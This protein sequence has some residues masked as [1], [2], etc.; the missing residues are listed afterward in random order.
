[1]TLLFL[2]MAERAAVWAPLFAEAGETM[3]IGEEAVTDPAEITHILCWVPPVDIARYPNLKV[4]ISVGAGADQ[5][6]PLPPGVALSR[7]I[8]PGIDGMVRDWIVM[9]TLMLH[10]D[11]PVYIAQGHAAQWAPRRSLPANRT[12]VGIMGLGRIGRLAAETLHALGF[13]VTGWCRSGTPLP[14]IEVYPEA[15]LGGFLS[16]SD[17]VICALPLTPATR[18]LLNAAFFAQLPKGAKLVHAGRS[19]HLVMEDLR[20]ALASGQLSNA[21]LDVTNPEPLP[22][23]HWAWSDPR[24]IIT[25]HIGSYTDYEEGARHALA[26]LRASRAGDPIPGRIDPARG[27]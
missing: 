14:G 23:D 6:P 24:L 3:I 12:R 9:A 20:R 7:T 4:I 27:Y 1:M 10:R 19:A 22:A 11:M 13:P 2:S 15:D 21:M 25:P 17:L 18:G 16:R 5:M 26:V 8:A